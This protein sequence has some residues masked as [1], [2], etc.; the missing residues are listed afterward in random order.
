MMLATVGVVNK[1]K[2]YVALM[3]SLDY[4]LTDYEHNEYDPEWDNW[5][6]RDVAEQGCLLIL[7]QMTEKFGVTGLV[8]ARF[9]ERWLA[10][11][12]WGGNDDDER[13]L[14]FMGSLTKQYRLNQICLPLFRNSTGRKQLEDAGLLPPNRIVYEDDEAAV[15]DIRM[16]NGEGTAGEDFASFLVDSMRPRRGQS[17]EDEDLRR[18]HREAMVLNDGS[19]PFAQGDIIERER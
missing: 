16:V 1:P 7:G 18:R 9:V 19:R 8:K 2:T 6:L 15:L 14:N 3:K 17:S 4:C 13:Q 5:N 12:P 10:K 11:E